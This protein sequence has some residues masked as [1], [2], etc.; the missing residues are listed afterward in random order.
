MEDRGLKISRKKTVRRFNF[1]GDRKLD[2]NSDS[3]LQRENLEKD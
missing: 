1:K 3:I 2:G